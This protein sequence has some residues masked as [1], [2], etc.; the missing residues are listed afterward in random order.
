MKKSFYA[1]IIISIISSLFFI[2]G[3][4]DN[5]T[6][7]AVKSNALG[8]GSGVEPD[9]SYSQE[10]YA[11]MFDT[12]M[13]YGEIGLYQSLASYVNMDHS[14]TLEFNLGIAYFW[15]KGHT[16][17]PLSNDSIFIKIDSLSINNVS[18]IRTDSNN[19]CMLMNP[20]LNLGTSTNH[21]YIKLNQSTPAY[22]NNISLPPAIKIEYPTLGKILYTDRKTVVKW[23]GTNNGYVYLEIR[24]YNF[25]DTTT[26]IPVA[27]GYIKDDGEFIINDKDLDK[28]PDGNYTLLLNRISYY[29][30]KFPNNNAFLISLN[31]SE[32][33]M[34]QIKH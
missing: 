27:K 8:L 10:Q 24:P 29:F 21:F 20:P 23:N 33:I 17:P 4:S 19:L 16:Y 18:F 9:E 5:P 26:T 13:I 32:S 22:D 34:L 14:S 25:Y 3:C 7:P 2:F 1:V 15:E 30:P 11:A 6:T 28:F 31:S 12:T